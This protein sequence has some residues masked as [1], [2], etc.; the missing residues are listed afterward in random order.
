LDRPVAFSRT[1]GL[2]G[3]VSTGCHVQNRSKSIKIA[4]KTVEKRLKRFALVFKHDET[5]Y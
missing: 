1:F 3:G 2:D 4:S 5:H